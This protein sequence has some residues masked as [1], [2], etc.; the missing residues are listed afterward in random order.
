M[1]TIPAKR[2]QRMCECR[3]KNYPCNRRQGHGGRHAFIWYGLGGR[4]RAVWG[5][6]REKLPL[7]ID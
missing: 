1:I 7:R 2:P 4:V 6:V 3:S 5:D